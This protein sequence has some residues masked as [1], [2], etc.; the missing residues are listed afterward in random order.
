M[1]FF[2]GENIDH[3]LAYFT[4]DSTDNLSVN[5]NVLKHSFPTQFSVKEI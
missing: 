3:I 1:I 2:L 5:D 4:V